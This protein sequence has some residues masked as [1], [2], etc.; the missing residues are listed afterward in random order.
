MVKNI[1]C[2]ATYITVSGVRK[3]VLKYVNNK[4][5][6]NKRLCVGPRGGISYKPSKSNTRRYVGHICKKAECSTSFWTEVERQAS[7][8]KN[9]TRKKR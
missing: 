2:V 5:K 3:R 6:T 9:S 1:K 7:L 8:K 4:K